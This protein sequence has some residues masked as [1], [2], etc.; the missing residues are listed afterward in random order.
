MSLVINLHS[1][2]LPLLAVP[3][4]TATP[5]VIYPAAEHHCPLTIPNYTAG[6]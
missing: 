1:S 5:T 6:W 3:L 4:H 2:R